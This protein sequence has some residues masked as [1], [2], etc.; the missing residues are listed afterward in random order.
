MAIIDNLPSL[1]TL[2]STDE[3]VVERGIT[4]YK[5]TYNVLVGPLNLNFTANDNTWSAIY[6]ILSKLS[7][8]QSAFYVAS[9]TPVSMLTNGKLTVV[10]K[11][12]VNR[13]ANGVYDF[14][15]YTGYQAQNVYVWR[16][17]G[18]TSASATPSFGDVCRYHG[19]VI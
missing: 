6:N 5:V 9:G 18:L 15:A 17:N 3:F 10:I 1:T 12:M 8:N 19:T 14:F 13:V 2:A 4:T 7:N 16:I 11:G